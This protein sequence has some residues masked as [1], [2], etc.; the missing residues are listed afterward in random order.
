MPSPSAAP[1]VR[2][3]QTTPPMVVTFDFGTLERIESE[4]G[5]TINELVL[6]DLE[7][8]MPTGEK[9]ETPEAKARLAKANVAR[10]KRQRFSFVIAFVA[11]CLR[12][13]REDLSGIVKPENLL[14]VLGALCVPFIQAVQQ[15]N[16]MDD[17]EETPEADPQMPSA[18]EPSSESIAQG[19]GG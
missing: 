18:I 6:E 1:S 12:C 7:P 2:L 8:F 3:E 9:P 4:M 15:I 11:A 19:S 10:F 16:G 14:V 5:K 17:D 13:P